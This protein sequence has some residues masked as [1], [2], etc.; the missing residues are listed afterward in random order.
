MRRDVNK[1][2]E[3]LHNVTVGTTT[4]GPGGIEGCSLD[5]QITMLV[6]EMRKIFPLVITAISKCQTVE[7]SA[8]TFYY[9]VERR[10]K[11]VNTIYRI[12]DMDNNN[13]K[14]EARN[15]TAYGQNFV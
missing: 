12:S 3:D 1:G 5:E 7:E 8:T 9:L 10:P 6:M 13:D 15:R 14:E 11:N 4:G 2:L